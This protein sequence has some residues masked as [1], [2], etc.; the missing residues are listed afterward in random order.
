MCKLG[1]R[2]YNEQSASE[3]NENERS[4]NRGGVSRIKSER[5]QH[6]TAGYRA[7]P[8]KS[9]VESFRSQQWT[10]GTAVTIWMRSTVRAAYHRSCQT[11]HSTVSS[12]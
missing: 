2:C 5:Y 1:E 3:P 7:T 10:I 9:G 12:T 4:G 11:Q 6:S 8:A